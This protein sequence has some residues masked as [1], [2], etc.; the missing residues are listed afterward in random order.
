[1]SHPIIHIEFSADDLQAAG[2]FYQEIFDWQIQ[3]VPEMNYTTFSWG[4]ENA[5]GGFNPVQEAYPA[6]TVIVYVQTEDINAT[7]E[8]INERGGETLQPPMPIPGVGQ[9]AIFSDPTGNRV[10]LVQPEGVEG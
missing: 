3:A 8:A 4:D 2:Q 9:I 1:M 10:G 6:G 7:L 5:G